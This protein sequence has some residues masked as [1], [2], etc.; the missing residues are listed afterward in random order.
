MPNLKQKTASGFKWNAIEKISIIIIS[1]VTN[2]ILARL[3]SPSDYGVIGM[4]AVFLSI[5]EVFV[6]S[7]LGIALIQK[8][9]R[10]EVDFS[11]AFYYN[12][13]VSIIFY[14][15]IY[16]TAPLIANF[17]S[18]PSLILITRVI[19]LNIIIA[20][21]GSLQ[22]IKLTIKID[23]KTQA[24][25]GLLSNVIAGIVSIFFAYKG[26]GVWVLV[27]Q[28]LL[29][30]LMMTLLRIYYVR[31]IP[32]MIF[33]KESFI[34]LFGYGSKIMFITLIDVM[35]NNLYNVII[36]RKYNAIDLGYFSRS[37]TFIQLPATNISSILEKVTFPVLSEIQDD[38]PRLLINY[39]KILKMAAF[40]TFPLMFAIV[41]LTKPLVL[42]FLTDKWLEIIPLMQILSFAYIFHSINVMNVNLLKVVGLTNLLVKL[43]IFKKIIVT[44][45]IF[46]T[47][48]FSVLGLCYGIVISTFLAFVANTIFVGRIIGHGFVKQSLDLLPFFI[49]SSIM[50]IFMY[51]SILPLTSNLVKL[52]VGSVVGIVFY[53]GIA[54]LLK[55]VELNELLNVIRKNG[56][57]KNEK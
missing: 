25:I 41:V 8:R 23:F 48:S 35:Y 4:L 46:F 36:G 44:A 40:I 42:F 6:N 7:G 37:N 5:S 27:I 55:F 26:Y 1:L 9:D 13:L 14:I 3:L 2:I 24:K 39:K 49:I 22:N 20:A 53:L 12:S 17:Y 11:T 19:G 51:Y 50:A 57:N 18:T 54:F 34:N 52:I 45:V 31:W 56:F 43:E 16:F 10:S 15:I 33:S 47:F 21:L 38:I 30:T 29:S 28:S 32:L